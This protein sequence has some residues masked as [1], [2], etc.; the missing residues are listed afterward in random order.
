[1]GNRL[2]SSGTQGKL[3]LR[4]IVRKERE[5]ENKDGEREC[6]V[7]R[8]GA[9]QGSTLESLNQA[10]RHDPGCKLKEKDDSNADCQLIR[11]ADS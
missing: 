4:I 9:C 10:Q 5:P 3:R 1:M 7:L 8:Q 2:T 6:H 11:F